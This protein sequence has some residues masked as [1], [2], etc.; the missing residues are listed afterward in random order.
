[1][2]T[3]KTTELIAR[4]VK[5][6]LPQ[7][8]R[9]MIKRKRKAFYIWGGVSTTRRW[10]EN[11]IYLTQGNKKFLLISCAQ[12]HVKNALKS[13]GCIHLFTPRRK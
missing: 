2:T 10:E 11:A 3:L 13:S 8:I 5:I 12:Q 9:E 1:M 7:T 4:S 6:Y